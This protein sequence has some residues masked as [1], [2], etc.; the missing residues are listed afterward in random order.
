MFLSK[1]TSQPAHEDPVVTTH[2]PL[3]YASEATEANG[4]TSDYDRVEQEQQEQKQ[5]RNRQEQELRE[6]E[7]KE[8]LEREEKKNEIDR[9]NSEPS[10]AP[11]DEITEEYNS[12]EDRVD[13][14]TKCRGDDTVRCKSNPTVEICDVQKCDGN[15]DCPNGE[16]E[17]DC[18]KS[19]ILYFYFILFVNDPRNF[20]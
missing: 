12:L 14:P 2:Y 8:W 17:E 15:N 3:L 9:F 19:G 1:G 16:D 13:K 18:P 6:R 11:I 10:E 5:Q 7:E 4:N 20:S